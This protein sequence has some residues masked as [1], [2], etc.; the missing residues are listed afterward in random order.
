LLVATG[1]S[2]TSERGGVGAQF[3]GDQQFRP[4]ALLLEQLAHQPQRRAAVAAAL[5]QHVENLAL[6][7]DGT[8]QIHP[9]AGD[10]HYH[11]IEVPAI[12]RPRTALTEPSRDRGTEFQHPAPHR[13]IGDV[14]PSFGQQLFDIAVAQGKAEIEPDRV[15]DDLG[16]GAMAAVAER[17]HADILSD[18]PLAPDPVSVTTPSLLIDRL[19]AG[20]LVD[21]DCAKS[22]QTVLPIPC[23]DGHTPGATALGLLSPSHSLA[24]FAAVSLI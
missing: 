11:L 19:A 12:A 18:T 17:S 15:L 10:A 1:Q 21:Q 4:E 13:F 20:M 14:E 2:Q 22:C 5:N 8:P 3:L 23:A 9:L 24:H 6:V 16:R 7:V